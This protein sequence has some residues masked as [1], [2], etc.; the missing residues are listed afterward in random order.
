[1]NLVDP[2]AMATHMHAEAYPGEDQAALRKPEGVTG[3]FVCL[4]MPEFEATGQ[5]LTPETT[6]S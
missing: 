5:L 3:I 6:L 1:M 2:G 4:A